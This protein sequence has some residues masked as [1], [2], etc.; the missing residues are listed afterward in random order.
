LRLAD[1]P[2]QRVELQRRQA[3]LF[4]KWAGKRELDRLRENGILFKD[5]WESMVQV[6]DEE[7]LEKKADLRA[8]L[9]DYP[10]LEQEMYLQAREDALNAERSA[11]GEASRRGLIS[12]DVNDELIIELNNR[13]AALEILMKN[14]GLGVGRESTD[15]E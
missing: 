10:E 3:T 4:A 15:H 8:H 2:P 5:I 9:Q 7:I 1:K 12:N 11:I 14:R 6:Y 13:V